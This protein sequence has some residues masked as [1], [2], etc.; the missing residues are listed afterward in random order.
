MAKQKI[1]RLT[2]KADKGILKMCPDASYVII[3]TP[4]GRPEICLTSQAKKGKI[5]NGELDIKNMKTLTTKPIII[6]SLTGSC[7]EF[8][9]EGGDYYFIEC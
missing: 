1:R 7:Y 6:N 2:N 3:C 5:V 9:C 8:I 4:G